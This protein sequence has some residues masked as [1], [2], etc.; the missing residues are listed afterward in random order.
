MIEAALKN[1]GLI[2]VGFK[3]LNGID[4]FVEKIDEEIVMFCTV[5]KEILAG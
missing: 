4:S 1:W 3:C 5:G 2:V